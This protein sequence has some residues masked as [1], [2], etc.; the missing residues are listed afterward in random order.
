MY[1]LVIYLWLHADVNSYRI[2]SFVLAQDCPRIDG[3]RRLMAYSTARRKVARS[4]G[5]IISKAAERMIKGSSCYCVSLSFHRVTLR[6]T[7]TRNSSVDVKSSTLSSVTQKYGLIARG[8]EQQGDCRRL[9]PGNWHSLHLSPWY[10]SLHLFCTFHVVRPL[11]V[12]KEQVVL[13][14]VPIQ[15]T[16]ATLSQSK[17]FEDATYFVLTYIYFTA[18][19]ST[20]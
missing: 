14:P 4:L 9:W 10:W 20:M 15:T 6:L 13:V 3:V 11:E 1:T 16:S 5:N 17:I 12:Q 18:N 8:L 7:C 19:F 2:C